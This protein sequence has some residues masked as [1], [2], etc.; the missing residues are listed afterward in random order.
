M[1]FSR[2]RAA[3]A[4]ILM[5][6]GLVLALWTL[7]PD[8][9]ILPLPAWA[10]RLMPVAGAYHIHTARSDGSGTI[11]EVAA[12]AARAGLS[13]VII[14]DHGDGT[15]VQPPEYRTGVLCIDAVEVSTSGGH[16]VAL[17]LA[18]TPYPLG[19]EPRD[20][21]AD[22]ARL[23]GFGIVA[24]PDSIEPA[25]HW[26]AWD[27]PFD[28]IEWI[29][30]DS[31][32]RARTPWHL[33]ASAVH[34]PAR[35][36]ETLVALFRRP[37]ENL[38]RWDALAAARRVVALAGADA[39]ARIG[40]GG[41]EREAGVTVARFPSYEA[42]FGAFS[43][44]AEIGRPL[45]GD[46]AEDARTILDA[47]RGGH[48][49]SAID[50][51]AHPAVLSFTARSG[52]HDAAEGDDLRLDGPVELR[53]RVNDPQARLVLLRDGVVAVERTGGELSFEAP[54]A[55]ATFRLEAR[56]ASPGAPDMP[57]IVSNPI[58]VLATPRLPTAPGPQRPAVA[59]EPLAP[60]LWTAERSPT[61]T[62]ALASAPPRETD[63]ADG[64][65]IDFALGAGSRASQYVAAV[66]N[67]P[68]DVARFECLVFRGRASRPMRVSVQLRD[69]EGRR[70]SRS[71][72]VGPTAGTLVVPFA[73][74]RPT[75]AAS[76]PALPLTTV[77]TILFV[78]DLT[79][80]SPGASGTL[81]LS[82]LRLERSSVPTERKRR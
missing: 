75:D 1:P 22:V 52:T 62:T 49:Y 80:A 45:V 21:V 7:P 12:A 60:A 29:N 61:S 76:S 16:Y 58:Y 65:Q 77:R 18:P 24:H 33:A 74:F 9:T 6:L 82:A 15:R 23:G 42:S 34:Y 32:R 31:E 69:A 5:A 20:V 70:W 30:A 38:S 67:A 56:R 68:A 54:A 44:H 26:D 2:R 36:A 47:V 10:P 41:T 57:W 51:L 17:D 14:T 3:A 46:A 37:V 63:G 43:I 71:I 40:W 53:A 8:A 78:V 55:P 79:N 19:G 27:L 64:V 73:E 25:L 13:F 81:W 72:Y 66:R 39:H 4:T 50:G 59:A 48:V 35:P 28:G 11:A